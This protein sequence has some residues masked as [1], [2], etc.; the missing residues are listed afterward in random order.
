MKKAFSALLCMLLASLC[1]C[2]AF[3]PSA[4]P[5]KIKTNKDDP[6]SYII[7]EY[8][9][10]MN[11]VN[12]N[13]PP[14]YYFAYDVD[15]NGSVEL[16][17]GT[18]EWDG[19]IVLWSVFAVQNGVSLWQEEFSVLGEGGSTL[20]SLV[21]RNGTIRTSSFVEEEW[22]K[23]YRFEAGVLKERAWLARTNEGDHYRFY[24]NDNA[25]H[26]IA[27]EEYDRVKAEMEGDGQVVELDWKPLTEYGR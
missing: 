13:V 19:E 6:N 11:D 20:P 4:T 25:K 7:E 9:G 3:G 15:S 24:P 26:P 1:A 17:L 10:Y 12:R 5:G 18:E 2:E 23:Y 16:L 14:Y 22:L 27:K 21:Y 8:Y